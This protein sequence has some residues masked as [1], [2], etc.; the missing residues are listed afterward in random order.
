LLS[1]IARR[2]RSPASGRRH[3]LPT[4]GRVIRRS[5]LLPPLSLQ[6]LRNRAGAKIRAIGADRSHQ[7]WKTKARNV[8]SNW[9]KEARDARVIGRIFALCCAACAFRAR[10]E[11]RLTDRKTQWRAFKRNPGH[12]GCLREPSGPG[13]CCPL[14][15]AQCAVQLRRRNAGVE[16]KAFRRL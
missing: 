15:S 11:A 10:A 13:F 6:I 9:G 3:Q 8:R 16:C 4:V 7:H 5:A 12:D 14:L 1:A 2:S